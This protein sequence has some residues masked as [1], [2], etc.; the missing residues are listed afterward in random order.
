MVNEA[1][2]A[3]DRRIRQLVVVGGGSA[4]WMAAAAL[5]NGLGLGKGGTARITL[6][7]SEEIGI[8]GVGEATI[9]PIR[10]LN[11]QLGLDEAAFVAEEVDRLTD[12]GEATPGQVAV[13]YRTNSGSRAL[14][15]VFIRLGIAYKVV[16]GV[17]FY[18]RRQV[19]DIVA[20]LR[21]VAN[22]EDTV[23]LRRIVNVPKRAI[24]DRAQAC[25]AVHSENAGISYYQALIDA[26]AGDVPMLNSRAVKQISGFVDFIE[27]LR[28][29]FLKCR[30]ESV[31]AVALVL[32]LLLVVLIRVRAV[33]RLRL[34]VELVLVLVLQTGRLA[35]SALFFSNLLLVAS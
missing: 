32:G 12:E 25:V 17:R 35:G 26:A 15:E 28:N 5:A 7:E 19:R 29:D 24:G 10:I 33:R 21:V 20:Y 3:D 27:G 11:Q 6:V 1:Q 18:E 4:G 8:V 22:P 14:E 16:G 9:P 34:G 2:T 30:P 31:Q 13:F 23:S